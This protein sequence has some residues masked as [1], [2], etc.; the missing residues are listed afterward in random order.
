[1]RWISYFILAYLMLGL[2][3]GII[4]YVGIGQSGAW[5]NLVLLAAIWIAI[6]APRD[7]ALL[8][9]FGLGLIQDLT[10]QQ[11]LGVFAF[12]YG[13]VAMFTVST[14]QVVYRAHPLTH[15]TLALIGS[16]LAG[17][18]VLIHGFYPGP[19]VSPMTLFYS[20]LYTAVLAPLVLGLLGRV[21]KLFAFQPIRR[22][23]RI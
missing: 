14:Q 16:F 10:S 6:N 12:S 3:I 23:M 8:G 11:T 4:S 21:K 1:M 13:L 7:A 22:K 15:F 17:I 2:Q 5:P 19:R 20:S 9:C 18:V